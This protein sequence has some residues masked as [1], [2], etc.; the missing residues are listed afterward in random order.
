M[1]RKKVRKTV[2][3]VLLSLFVIVIVLGS[4]NIFRK[5]RRLQFVKNM[6]AGINI[7][8][9]MDS[10]GLREYHPEATDLEYETYWGNPSI[11]EELFVCI[12][13]AGF[14]T[15]RIPVTWQDHMREDGTI[16]KEWMM[17]VQEVVDMAME[18]ELYVII[19]THHEEWL[20]LKTENEEEIIG[21]FKYVWEQI[22]E[23]FQLY[24]S[25]LLFE[26]MN[27]PR[28]RNSEYEWTEGTEELRDMVNRLN[29][30]FVETVRRGGKENENRYL[31][32]SPYA[33]NHLEG[34][35][36]ALIIPRGNIIVSIHMYAPYS[37][38]QDEEGMN[39]WNPD[40]E[41]VVEYATQIEHCFDLMGQYFVKKG[42]PVI[43]T[44][45][46]CKNKNNTDD[47]IEWINFYKQQADIYGIPCIWWDNGSNYQIID[48]EKNKWVYP[49]IKDELI[50]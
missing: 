36:E 34:V 22:A 10:H 41:E 4:V 14:S 18:Q 31:L 9:T 48:R 43:L 40:D 39:S 37:F 38:C 15:V 25:R 13:E 33:C 11:T 7:G 42:I 49:Q 47:R 32:V 8:N 5:V 28:L 6:G 20:D 3:A 44:E 17:R 35:M 16:N 29:S 24:D 19:N 1:K 26:G 50:K 27:E 12:K 46:G 2:T 30:V 45:F 21:R 23:Q